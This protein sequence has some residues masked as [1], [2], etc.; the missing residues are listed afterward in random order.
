MNVVFSAI[1]AAV[2]FAV[3]LLGI[4]YITIPNGAVPSWKVDGEEINFPYTFNVDKPR[5]ME[6]NAMLKG[7]GKM[8]LVLPRMGLSNIEVFLN[9]KM[10]WQAG[11]ENHHSR[12][13]TQTFVV[14]LNLAGGN[15]TLSVKSFVL[16]D[17]KVN[18]PPY[19]SKSPW[20]KMFLSN[21]FFSEFPTMFFGMAI[22]LGILMMRISHQTLDPAGN[23]LFGISLIIAGL[24]ILDY[25]YIGLFL[26]RRLYLFTRRIG[27][28]LPYL[29]VTSYFYSVRRVVLKKFTP[30]KVVIPM[31]VVS[32]LPI[33]VYNFK[34]ARILAFFLSP[35]I[36]VLV[37]E[38]LI[39]I[40][41]ERKYEFVTPFTFLFLST[42]YSTILVWKFPNP[43][44]LT[45]GVAC[46]IVAVIKH[47]Y[48]EYRNLTVTAILAQKKSLLDPLTGA[49][50][51][52][53]FNEIPPSFR[54]TL[55]FIDL[56]GFKAFNDTYGHEEGDEVLRRFADIVM[57]RLRKDDI[58]IRYGGDEFV[59]L[60]NECSPEKAIEVVEDI[61][62]AFKNAVG[63]TFS[64]GI[65][66][67]N[68]NVLESIKI[69]DRR[70]Y[71]M[72]RRNMGRARS[73]VTRRD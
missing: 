53:V 47:L 57:K 1:R 38:M 22:V 48:S 39:E 4:T 19:L 71:D 2:F 46:S 54:G 43:G 51:R 15:N 11:D 30:Q 25:S 13:W 64:Y 66:E 17:V 65:S 41:S 29:S 58:F 50:N 63:L 21:L 60:L 3:L 69:A 26:N 56:D 8:F 28:S 55:V 16:Y 24:F 68:G 67:F 62:N 37:A 40:I 7:N 31:I 52:R 35:I 6:I 27:Y 14:P 33:V 70:M 49:F 23:F 61:K 5:W 59:I 36:I 20:T 10:I 18:W 73:E 42:L 32:I 45:F 72:K 12:M 44:V 34:V 9:G